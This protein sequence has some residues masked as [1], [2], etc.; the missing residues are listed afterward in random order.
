MMYTTTTVWRR[1]NRQLHTHACIELPNGA[2]CNADFFWEAVR[3][4][5]LSPDD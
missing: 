1:L 5:F 3:L 2:K 4:W